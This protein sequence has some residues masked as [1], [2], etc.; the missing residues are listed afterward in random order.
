MEKEFQGKP[1]FTQGA[2]QPVFPFTDGKT[3]ENYNAETSDIVRYCVYI[4]SDLD[5][6]QDGQRDLVKAFVQV[7]RSAAEG[8][9]KAGTIFEARPYT[10]GVMADAYAHLKEVQDKTYAQVDK[11][12]FREVPEKSIPEECISSLE[13]SYR[14]K[15]SE[16][17]YADK[18]GG[19]MAYDN[20]DLYNYYLVRGFAVVESSGFGTRGS[21]GFE[22]VGTEFEQES[23]K[24]VV[25]W[26]HGDRTGFTSRDKKTEVKADFAN[27]NVG[28]TG[29]SYGGTMPFA[30]A[31][32]GVEGLKTIVPVAGIASWYDQQNQQGAQRYWPKEVL[33]AMLAYYCASIYSDPEATKAHL[34]KV[35]A[36]HYQMSMDQIA[37]GF[38]YDDDFWGPGNYTLTA[39]QIRCSAL[40]VHGLN[41][42]NVSTKQFEMMYKAFKKA[43]N[44]VKLLLHQGYHMTPNMAN[45]GFG[46]FV[47]GASYDDILN[48][49]YSHYLFDVENGAESF[50]E[51]LV[52]D[53][54]NQTLWHRASAW[55]TDKALHVQVESENFVID[56]DWETAGIDKNVFDEKMS[57]TSSNMNKRFG[58]EALQDEV[59]LQGTVRVDFE[60]ALNDGDAEHFFNGTNINDADTLTMKTGTDSGH[61]EDV[62]MTVMLCDV[63]D[64]PFNSLH[65][66]DPERNVIRHK[67][68]NKG[69]IE[70]GGGLP[71]FDEIAFE[72]TL[73][74]FKVITRSYIDLCNPAS[75]YASETSKESIT[76]KKGE[77]H[78][79]HIFLN[80]QR[81]T[82][83]PGHRLVLVMTTEDP[84]FCLIHKDYKVE[85]KGGSIALDIPVYE[86]KENSLSVM[87]DLA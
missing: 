85:V 16:W 27:G 79:Y 70:N 34:E 36:Y 64:T 25:E 51:V 50:D 67:V 19:G 77:F 23:F 11:T 71:A 47:D 28:M 33:N 84:V 80:P 18:G 78:K 59:T 63:C 69:V 81:Y 41:D 3:G 20:I 53:N 82:V 58:T 31:A 6:D 62:K 56:T 55:E 57:L 32:T 49:W 44:N 76:L 4:E 73:S 40:I 13:A 17:Y 46:F 74:P 9:Y 14:A 87:Q 86:T 29:R 45:K 30:V 48:K 35:A 65:A 12:R 15:P 83:K 21:D 22:C 1:V 43:G 2:A 37:H 42:E 54:A 7:P 38:D 75:G 61:M 66:D 72:E 8:K 5:M 68:L 60:A 24:N 26:L 39:D 52:Q 10:A